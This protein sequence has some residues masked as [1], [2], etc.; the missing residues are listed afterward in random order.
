MLCSLLFALVISSNQLTGSGQVPCATPEKLSDTNGASWS[1]GS[2]VNVVIN[3][4]D[5]N[6]EQRAAIRAGFTTWQNQNGAS[7]NNP[8]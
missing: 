2:S 6:P 1:K 7:G 8:V 3:T 5:F 4:N